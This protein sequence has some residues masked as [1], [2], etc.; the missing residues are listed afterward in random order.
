M[1]VGSLVNGATIALHDA[2]DLSELEYYHIKLQSHDIIYAEGVPCETLLDVEEGAVNFVE[3]LRMYGAPNETAQPCIP[4][5]ELLL[6]SK[7]NEVA[8]SQRPFAFG[9]SA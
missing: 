4:G 6:E 2:N 1:R 3:Y 8:S 5:S 7:Q 9:G